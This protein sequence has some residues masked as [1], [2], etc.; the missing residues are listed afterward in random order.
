[1]KYNAWN[2]Q[3]VVI[4]ENEYISIADAARQLNISKAVVKYRTKETTT[5]W[6]TWKRL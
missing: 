4:D 5:N 2:L 6:P 1:M 3:K